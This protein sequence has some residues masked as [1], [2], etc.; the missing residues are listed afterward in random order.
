MNL[1]FSNKVSQ[2]FADK[3]IS[4]SKALPIEPDWAMFIMNN[5][6]GLNSA[7]VNSIG[8]VG[9]IQF[10][11]DTGGGTTKTIGGIVYDLNTVKN[12]NPVDQLDLVFDYWKDVQKQFGRLASYHDLY[13]ATFYPYAIDQPD[14]YILGSERSLTWAAKVGGQN[15]VFDTNKDGLI[16]KGEF[17]KWLDDKVKLTIAT[18]YYDT[19]FKKKSFL[20]LYKREI[21]FG[22]VI[23]I[24]VIIMVFTYRKLR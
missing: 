19:F 7:I 6:S 2:Q 21:V 22:I 24:L 14:N 5:E 15:K 3:V 13:L 17:K 10:C 12:M 20:Q 4:K 23:L 11:P 16:T 9:L 18:D 8:C 1:L